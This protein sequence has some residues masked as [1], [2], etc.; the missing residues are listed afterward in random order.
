ML[1]PSHDDPF[2]VTHENFV[3]A[4]SYLYFG[5][6]VA[7]GGFGK[8]DHTRDV[9]PLDN[10]TVIR[11]N[12]DTLYSA[13]IFDLHAGPVTITMPDAEGRFMSLQVI[14][15]DQYTYGVFYEPGEYTLD[16]S[17]IETRYVVAAVRTLVDPA[18]DEDMRKVHALQ[19]AITVSQ[20]DSGSWSVPNWDHQSQKKVR[21]ALLALA[22]TLPDTQRMYGRRGEVD[23]VRFLIGAAQG[24]GANPPSE[25]L[26]LNV[27]PERNDGSTI[28]RL[29]VGD[30]PVDGFWSVCVYNSEGY[31]E[32]NSLNSYSLNNIT[33]KK[34]E[35]GRIVVQFGGCDGSVPN[36]LPVMPNWNYMVRLY[37]PRAEVLDGSWT[38]PEA[39]PVSAE[40]E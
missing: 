16:S 35:H 31:F 23:P 38:F 3:R 5:G 29:E 9:A 1:T 22:S 19:D 40:V 20:A 15:E 11:L 30:V 39:S 17:K 12:L 18:D 34:D 27:V 2:L 7:N 21:E 32:Q 8:F 28:Y 13:S 36:C 24:W 6:V 10:Q 4:E 26:Y 37:R 14:D 25:A 33:A